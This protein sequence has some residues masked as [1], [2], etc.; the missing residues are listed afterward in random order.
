[1]TAINK[2]FV[3]GEMEA[4][5]QGAPAGY[6]WS[7]LAST[8]DPSFSRGCVTGGA[9]GSYLP[10]KLTSAQTSFWLSA[11]MFWSGS[12]GHQNS[13]WFTLCDATLAAKYRVQGVGGTEL[14]PAI[15]FQYW[16]GAAWANVA[17]TAVICPTQTLHKFDFHIDQPTG[18]VAAWMDGIPFG[19]Q[20]GLPNYAIAEAQMI[21]VSGNSGVFTGISEVMCLDIQ[22]LGRRL[23]TL[24]EVANGVNTD[25]TGSYTDI[26]EVGTFNDAN[27]IQTGTINKTST[28][29]MTTPLSVA[30]QQY[31]ISSLVIAGRILIGAVGPQNLKG[32]V[33]VSGTT[34]DSTNDVANLLTSFGYTWSDFDENPA[35]GLDWTVAQIDSGTIETGWKSLT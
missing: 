29:V 4:F 5:A 12:D 23:S 3:G 7:T 28:F 11:Q 32:A 6:G 27:F 18:T 34:Y 22:T 15:L 31:L 30:A 26:N 19:N 24:G 13:T 9:T 2:Y 16:T 1:M 33:V 20:T 10:I 21:A 8:F 17:G 25:W 35:T 14:Q